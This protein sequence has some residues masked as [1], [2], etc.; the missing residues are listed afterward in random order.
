M[1]VLVLL[2]E[3]GR[4]SM[5][6]SEWVGGSRQ[7]SICWDAVAFPTVGLLGM[8]SLHWEHSRDRRRYCGL[9]FRPA[10]RSVRMACHSLRLGARPS[11]QMYG[12][13]TIKVKILLKPYF[14]ALA[15]A[16]SNFPIAGMV[17]GEMEN[18]RASLAPRASPVIQVPG[19]SRPEEASDLVVTYGKPPSGG[20]KLAVKA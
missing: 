2:N 10:G 19:A 5:E 3:C 7:K 17:Q 4:R 6:K 15:P 1:V 13:A 20:R 14:W 11:W 9:S 12:T 16:S 8:A 18:W